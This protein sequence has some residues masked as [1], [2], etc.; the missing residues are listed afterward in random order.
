MRVRSCFLRECPLA[1]TLAPLAATAV[2][3]AAGLGAAQ[4]PQDRPLPDSAERAYRVLAPRV[5]GYAAMDVVTFMSQ[6]W[7]VAGNP[8][9]NASLE[10]IRARLARSGF[11]GGGAG[12][13]GRQRLDE[14]PNRSPG[15]DYAV[16]TLTFAGEPGD[17][18][19]SRERDRVSSASTRSPHPT[20]A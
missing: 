13:P 14:Y 12:T 4:S 16:G 19:L 8:G 17:P 11:S 1:R 15:W 6:Y 3:L 9:Y 20:A 2:A 18:V 5:S 10:D 7:R